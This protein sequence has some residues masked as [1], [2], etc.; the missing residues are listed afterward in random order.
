M[1]GVDDQIKRLFTSPTLPRRWR[2]QLLPQ[3]ARQ[4]S[5]PLLTAA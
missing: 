3:L 1:P 2:D 4:T 5:I